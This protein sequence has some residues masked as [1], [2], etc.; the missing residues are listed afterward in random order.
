M[1]G[2]A[3]SLARTSLT[4]GRLEVLRP[5]AWG[6][7]CSASFTHAAASVACRQMGKGPV[8]YA[9]AAS[10][11][12]SASAGAKQ[13]MGGVACTGAEA[14]L[15]DCAFSGWGQSSCSH[16]EDVGVHCGHCE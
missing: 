2:S 8:G 7:V 5:D 14:R 10:V 16:A 3:D 12:G 1:R 13:W 6:T 11:Y 4:Q 9:A 15:Q